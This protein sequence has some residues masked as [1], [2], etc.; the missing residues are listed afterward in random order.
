MHLCPI[1]DIQCVLF[2]QE[3][4]VGGG[5]SYWYFYYYYYYYY[6]YTSLTADTPTPFCLTVT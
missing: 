3:E 6:R 5:G 2:S 4:L 1:L